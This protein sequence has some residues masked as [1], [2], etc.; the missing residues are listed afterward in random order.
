MKWFES[1]A[2][3]F[4]DTTTAIRVVI[5]LLLPW[6]GYVYGIK[7]LPAAVWLMLADWT[8]DAVDGAI[9]RRNRPVCHTWLG[10]HDLQVD[11]L[12]S[13]GLLGYLVG[14]D[15]VSPHLA[16]LYVLVW[17]LILWQWQTPRS[18]GMLGQAPIYG[19]FILTAVYTRPVVGGWL[20]LWVIGAMIITWPRFPQEV[21][22]NFLQGMRN[23]LK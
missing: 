22:P 13:A 1:N 17:A 2:K 21:V 5:A 6:L 20:L 11:I 12:V 7:G 10:D 18:L 9:A 16:G 8:G 15:F 4:A 19:W 14:A 3:R 23:L